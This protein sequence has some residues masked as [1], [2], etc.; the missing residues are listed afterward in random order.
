MSDTNLLDE[1]I[2]LCKK[3]EETKFEGAFHWVF[4]TRKCFDRGNIAF[5]R[6]FLPSAYVSIVKGSARV[7]HCSALIPKIGTCM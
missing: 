4:S 3:K 6:P 7:S 2:H 1:L 5:D